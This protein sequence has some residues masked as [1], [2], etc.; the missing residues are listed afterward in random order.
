MIKHQLLDIRNQELTVDNQITTI[1]KK[2]KMNKSFTTISSSMK[3]HCTDGRRTSCCVKSNL[4]LTFLKLNMIVEKKGN[5]QN[6]MDTAK[7]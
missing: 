1:K 5:R 6:R 4:R 7:I 3:L 2:K